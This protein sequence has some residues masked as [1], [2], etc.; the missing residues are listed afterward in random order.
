MAWTADRGRRAIVA[1]AARCTFCRALLADGRRRGD[2][3]LLK[4][5]DQLALEHAHN[6]ADREAF[7]RRS[8]TDP[9]PAQPRRSSPRM[10]L[11]GGD[12]R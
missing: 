2:R 4:A 3:K 10:G 7:A 11:P 5:A 6:D 9:A 8:N 12:R 1:H